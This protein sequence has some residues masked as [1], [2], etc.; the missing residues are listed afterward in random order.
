MILDVKGIN[1]YYGLSHIVFDLSLS[2]GGGEVVAFL[3]R[4]GAGR[5]TTLKSIMGIVPP[6]NGQVIFK[7]MNITGLPSYKISR[8]GIGIVPEDRRIFSRL[9]VR[10]NMEI[11]RKKTFKGSSSYKEWTVKDFFEI[12][13][14]LEKRADKPGGT[15]SGGEQQMLTIARTMMGNPQLLLLDEPTEGLAPMI[16]KEIMKFILLLKD[17]SISLILSEQN[18][19]FSLTPADR[20]Y[21]IEKGKIVYV[22]TR[23]NLE[24]DKE[25]IKTYLAV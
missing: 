18:V 24:S 11:S 25:L 1:T 6:R 7:G 3:G 2:V 14:S 15:L 17:R 16:I 13:P 4:N 21:I 5:T 10:E 20:V 12:F 9:S 23:E 8:L 19:K 22:G